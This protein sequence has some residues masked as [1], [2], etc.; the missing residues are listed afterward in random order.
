MDCFKA[1]DKSHCAQW[2]VLNEIQPT[3]RNVIFDAFKESMRPS[4]CIM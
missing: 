2:V 3:V 1:V 4:M